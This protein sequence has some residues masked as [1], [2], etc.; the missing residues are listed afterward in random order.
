MRYVHSFV[1]AIAGGL[2]RV[3]RYCMLAVGEFL[4]DNGSHLSASIA[5]Y[6]LFSILPVLLAIDLIAIKVGQNQAMG[7]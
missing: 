1:Q 3:F 4:D 2:K 6:L 5:Y 7:T